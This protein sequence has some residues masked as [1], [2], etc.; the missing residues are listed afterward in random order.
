MP[1]A[2]ELHLMGLLRIGLY[3]KRLAL[4][5]L[6]MANIGPDYALKLSYIRSALHLARFSK[7]NP[8]Y[9]L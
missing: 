9:H 2:T 4:E 8:S 5:Q 6:D 3:Q 7:L 1:L